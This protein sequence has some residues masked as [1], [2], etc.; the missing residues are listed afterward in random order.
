MC[1]TLLTLKKSKKKNLQFK[2][3]TKTNAKLYVGLFSFKI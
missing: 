3:D 1:N 2:S